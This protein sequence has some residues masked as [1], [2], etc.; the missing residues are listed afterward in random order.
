MKAMILAAGHGT[1]MRPLTNHLPKPLL[2]VY[3]KSLLVWHLER[4]K[5][6]GFTDIVINIS[7]CGHKIP[8]ALGSG[9]QWGLNIQYSDEQDSGALETAGGIAKAL[10]LLGSEPFLVTNGDVWCEYNYPKQ[11]LAENDLAHLVLIKN[12]EHN[13][14]GDFCLE[15]GR[16]TDRKENQVGITFSG[17]GYYRPELFKNI[18][19]AGE[20]AAL[21]PLLRAAMEKGQVSGE[22]YHGIWHD[23][24][25][26]KRLESL[27]QMLRASASS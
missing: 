11:S 1:R 5:H 19:P 3:D 2:K 23:I 18:N 15:K 17:I 20:K 14:S 6:A 25:T 16:I 13:L 10:P 8:E 22:Y 27:D 4:L 12:P 26:P 7:W 21:A 24:G 9:S